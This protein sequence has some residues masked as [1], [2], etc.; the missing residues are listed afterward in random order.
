M[1]GQLAS[2]N[3]MNIASMAH[4]SGAEMPQTQFNGALRRGMNGSGVTIGVCGQH[5]FN[6]DGS[7]YLA[8]QRMFR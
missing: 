1:A 8:A 3:G 7:Y 2:D 6:S 5:L 4:I